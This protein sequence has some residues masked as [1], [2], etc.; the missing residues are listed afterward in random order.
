[1]SVRIRFDSP[2]CS[3]QEYI[4]SVIRNSLPFSVRATS[5]FSLKSKRKTHVFC[6]L[7]YHFLSPVAIKPMTSMLVFLWCVCVCL[8]MWF[9]VC[10]CV[11]SAVACHLYMCACMCVCLCVCVCVCM[12]VC[13]GGVCVCVCICMYVACVFWNECAYLLLYVPWALMRWG[14]INYLFFFFF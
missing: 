14:A 10:M 11:V 6:L 13:V 1:M 4:R 8:C 5:L 9:C 7:I 3:K 2:L 12:H